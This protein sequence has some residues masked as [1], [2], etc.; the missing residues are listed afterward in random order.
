MTNDHENIVY[1]KVLR[2][3]VLWLL[4][5]NMKCVKTLVFAYNALQILL[6]TFIPAFTYFKAFHMYGHLENR[7]CNLE[8][9]TEN[10]EEIMYKDS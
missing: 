6:L 3:K 2:E 7:A 4:V 1:L 9:N 10:H 8:H 5:L